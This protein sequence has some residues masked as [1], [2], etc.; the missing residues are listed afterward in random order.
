[1]W[2]LTVQII[3]WVVVILSVIKLLTILIKPSAWMGVVEFVYGKPW[4]TTIVALVLGYVTLMTLLDSGIT[5]VQI[6]GV[7]LFFM[8]VMVLTFAAYS[9]D[10]VA[11]G[12]KWLKQNNIL[13][14]AW[15][16]LIVWVVLLIWVIMELI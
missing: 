11:L 4:L 1:M 7:M 13:K 10:A 5:I 2:G 14:K 8:F 16:A 12:K 3:A 15:V 9:K 6:F